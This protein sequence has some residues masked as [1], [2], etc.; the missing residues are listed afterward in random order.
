ML[1][2]DDDLEFESLENL[3]MDLEELKAR[4]TQLRLE[5]RRELQNLKSEFEPLLEHLHVHHKDSAESSI[6]HQIMEPK[7]K[8]KQSFSSFEGE[9]KWDEGGFQ[10]FDFDEDEEE[11]E[12]EF[13]PFVRKIQAQLCRALH[14]YQINQKQ[15]KLSQR[16]NKRLIVFL[17]TEIQAQ[18]AVAKRRV[19]DFEIE[20]KELKSGNQI[21]MKMLERDA[22][23]QEETITEMRLQLGMDPTPNSQ[24]KSFRQRHRRRMQRLSGG[25][26]NLGRRV[27]HAPRNIRDSKVW[28]DLVAAPEE[29]EEDYDAS[30]HRDSVF[31]R[32][33]RSGPPV[34][35]VQGEPSTMP[36]PPQQ[37][38]NRFHSSKV[39]K[40][41][42][43]D[44][45]ND[46]RLG[47]MGRI[48]RS[49]QMR[50]SGVHDS[51]LGNYLDNRSDSIGKLQD[52]NNSQR[53]RPL[54]GGCA[55]RGRLH[56]E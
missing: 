5:Y 28:K 11:E 49:R 14:Q 44:I 47:L 53:L 50:Q 18:K 37:K 10:D 25:L 51:E 46:G 45:E 43:E 55:K 7:K 29:E 56:R 8:S 15:I 9:E 48:R 26:R 52:D 42:L 32:W 2:S 1:S 41:P 4:G 30:E 12:P 31:R 27:R 6:Y 40:I 22:L 38:Q 17:S 23:D 36:P 34:E 33:R 35:E 54:Q 20:F 24:R 19:E 3:R 13:T 39:E 21:M 16:S